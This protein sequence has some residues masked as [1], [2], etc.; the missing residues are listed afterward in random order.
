M[1]DPAVDTTP[2]PQQIVQAAAQIYL[3]FSQAP[4]CCIAVYD[5]DAFGSTGYVYPLGMSAL[6]GSTPPPFSVTTDTVF[7][8]GSV[9][10]VFTSTLLAQALM[11][12]KGGP[13]ITDPVGKWLN[14]D[15][16]YGPGQIGSPTLYALTLQ[17][18]VTHTSGMFDQPQDL[19]IP[20][21]KQLFADGQPDPKLVNWWNIY[22]PPP[23][24]PQPPPPGCWQYSNIGFVTLG[25]AVTQM[26]SPDRGVNYNTILAKYIT[27]PLGMTQTGAT[28]QP[29]WKV[30]QGCIGN[31]IQFPNPP[32]LIV[33]ENNKPTGGTAFDLKTTGDDMLRFLAAQAEAPNG[34]LGKVI[35]STQ[36]QQSKYPLCES[37]SHTPRV[38]MG[39]GWQMSYTQSGHAVYMKNGATSLGGFEAIVIVVPDFQCGVAVLSN[40]YLDASA[41]H[42]SQADL[43]GVARNIIAHLHPGFGP[44]VPLPERDVSE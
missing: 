18:L 14:Y 30:A 22:P 43:G 23:P 19:D 20:Y 44:D 25:F 21:S 17:D 34:P 1:S 16:T 3:D 40:Q 39:L 10:K 13:S 12:T 33:F 28:I 2:S 35:Q 26:F 41:P 6:P 38:P 32:G 37:N 24:A 11:M 42:P 7:E 9:T 5:H 31:W 36:M 29:S 8:I 4:G 27:G 15:H